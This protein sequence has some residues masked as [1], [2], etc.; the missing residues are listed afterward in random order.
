LYGQEGTTPETPLE[1]PKPEIKQEEASEPTAK[2]PGVETPESSALWTVELKVLEKGTGVPVGRA[3]VAVGSAKQFTNKEG[4]LAL[5]GN[6]GVFALTIQ[7]N[8]FET[9]EIQIDPESTK[10]KTIYLMPSTPSDNEVLVKAQKRPEV[11]KKILTIAE[12]SKAAPGGDPGQITKVLPG[13][14]SKPLG[15]QIAVRGSGPNDTIYQVDDIKLPFL[16]HPIGNISILPKEYLS[17]IEFSSGGYGS[18]YGLGTGGVVKLITT[19]E[20]PTRSK[21]SFTLNVPF[22]AAAYTDKLIDENRWVSVGVRKSTIEYILPSLLKQG[23]G[24]DLTLVPYFADV[25]VSYSDVSSGNLERFQYLYSQDGLKLAIPGATGSGEEGKNQFRVFLDFHAISYQNDLN[26]GGGWS[27][28]TAP[29]TTYTTQD[30]DF[31]GN[32]V[33]LNFCQLFLNT[34]VTKRLE[35]K[36]KLIFGVEPAYLRGKVDVNAIVFQD[37]P[38]FDPESAPKRAVVI[39]PRYLFGSAWT[40]AELNFGDLYLAPGLRGSWSGQMNKAIADPRLSGRYKLGIQTLKFAVGS[41]SQE[42]QPEALSEVYGNPDLAYIRSMHYILGWERP[43]EDRWTIDLQLFKKDFSNIVKNFTGNYQNSG[44]REAIGFEAF[45]RREFTGRL[46][47][48]LAYTYSKATDVDFKGDKKHP[49]EYDQ[50]HVFHLLGSYKLTSDWEAGGRLDMN[51]GDVF[52]GI[53]DVYYNPNT[54][55][56]KAKA[57]PN[58][59]GRR[60]PDYKTMSIYAEKKSFYDTW[61][62]NWRFG[63]EGI[64]F[65]KQ[66]INMQYNYDYSKEELFTA[67]PPIPYIEVRAEL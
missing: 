20:A 36:N 11:S 62:L 43:I 30:S 9:L 28:H 37:D 31:N 8:G 60:L 7:R 14:Q 54:D 47:G 64:G 45:L 24:A 51:T 50:T 18:Q 42:P 57:S 25:V 19:T 40:G 13:V 55:A 27:L 49:A 26:L 39:K 58:T 67:L 46:F 34:E 59:N 21:S 61:T 2:E 33:K 15:S 5:Q 1:S 10:E 22:L 56:Y 53:G 52:T 6:T 16:F 32:K 44:K 63:V 65:G 12:A 23:D 41:Y 3:E 29:Y 35:G 66:A 17:Q 48:W 38:F 4:L